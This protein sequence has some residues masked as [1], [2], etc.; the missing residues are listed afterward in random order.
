MTY[1]VITPPK[2]TGLFMGWQVFY[3]CNGADKS[4][5]RQICS[6]CPEIGRFRMLSADLF[7]PSPCREFFACGS[8]CKGRAK[9]R[10]I[11]VSMAGIIGKFLLI[12]PII[13]HHVDFSA[14]ILS[15]EKTMRLPSDD[16]EGDLSCTRLLVSLR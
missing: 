12:P 1:Y 14:P 16:H 11:S 10:R 4:V 5:N 7:E 13:V 2:V 3:S 8:N 9:P 6:T 15:D